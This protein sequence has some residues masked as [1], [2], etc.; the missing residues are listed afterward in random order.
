MAKIP[1]SCAGKISKLN[2]KNDEICQV[3]Q[4]LLEME[5]DDSV[6]IKSETKKEEPA[7]PAATKEAPSKTGFKDFFRGPRSSS[8]YCS[9]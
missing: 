1:S 6:Q 7:A 8:G 3:G 2:Y 4:T 5:V 9:G